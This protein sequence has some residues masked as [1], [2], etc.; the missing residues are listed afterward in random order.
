MA[1]ITQ[2]DLLRE[3]EKHKNLVYQHLDAM[4]EHAGSDTKHQQQYVLS[5]AFEDQDAFAAHAAF[6]RAGERSNPRSNYAVFFIKSRIL[7]IWNCVIVTPKKRT[8]CICLTA[9]RFK[10]QFRSGQAAVCFFHSE[11]IKTVPPPALF[12]AAIKAKTGD[13]FHIVSKQVTEENAV[14]SSPFGSVMMRSR[15]GSFSAPR[16]FSRTP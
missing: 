14:Q 9:M 13:R 15:I 10:R 6:H 11:K 5:G 16:S 8:M 12:S 2:S 7:P 3:E 1:V 4:V